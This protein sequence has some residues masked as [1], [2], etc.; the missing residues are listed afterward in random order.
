VPL[1]ARWIEPS[2]RKGPLQAYA[3]DTE[4]KTLDLLEQPLAKPNYHAP[5]AII[6]R[7]LLDTAIRDIEELLPQ[8]QPRAEEL[9]RIAG[10][11]LRQR[12]KREEKDL[13]EILERQLESDVRSWRM[14][15]DQFGTDIL[16]EPKRIRDFYDV[17]AKRVEPVGLVYLWPET[18]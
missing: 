3:R 8:L 13:R 9:A 11:K 2:Q 10:E 5:G 7:K 4:L 1:A 17:H 14:R 12:G 6:Q 18:N 16:R 15:I